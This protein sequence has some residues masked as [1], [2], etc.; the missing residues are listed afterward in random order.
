MLFLPMDFLYTTL[1]GVSFLLL[2]VLPTRIGDFLTILQYILITPTLESLHLLKKLYN[3]TVAPCV[4]CPSCHK[5]VHLLHHQYQPSGNFTLAAIRLWI[6]EFVTNT[7]YDSIIEV[8][9]NLQPASKHFVVSYSSA[10]DHHL[11]HSRQFQQKESN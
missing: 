6:L 8:I 10:K 1:G 5:M 9:I 7:V 4:Q 11:D 3:T 2:V